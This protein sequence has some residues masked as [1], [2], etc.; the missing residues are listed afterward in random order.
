LLPKLK[1]C[2]SVAAEAGW[3][4]MAGQAERHHYR[5]SGRRKYA[6][7]EEFLLGYHV[8]AW[9][10]V[11]VGSGRVLALPLVQLLTQSAVGA[12]HIQAQTAVLVAE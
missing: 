8:S 9:C 3:L 10:E 12:E 1:T 5:R 7:H 6:F 11:L 2:V 4:V